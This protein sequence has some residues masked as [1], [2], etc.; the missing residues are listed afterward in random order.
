[1][2]AEYRRETEHQQQRAGCWS[3]WGP[4]EAPSGW[5]SLLQLQADFLPFAVNGM[6]LDEW[7]TSDAG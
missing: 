4:K 3:K 6:P 2:S 5:M 1:M 7:K